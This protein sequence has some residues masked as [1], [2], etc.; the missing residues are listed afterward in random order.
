MKK[1][2]VILVFLLAISLTTAEY[3]L[4]IK[5]D[6]Q[7]Y[8]VGE[9]LAYQALLLEDGAP[10][11][12]QV[13]V[14]FSDA[15]EK[16]QITETV[17]SNIENK[18]L[19]GEDFTSGGWKVSATYKEKTVESRPFLIK[20][21]TAVEFKIQGKKLIITNKGNTPYQKQIQI[22]IGED[23]TPQSV[24]IGVGKTKELTLVAPEGNY[25]IKVTDGEN[26]VTKKA[27]YLTG[28]GNAIGAYDENLLSGGLIGGTEDP[29]NESFSSSSKMPIALIFVGAVFGLGILFFIERRLS[30]KKK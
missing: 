27:V 10:I 28:T 15:L 16:K 17:T 9:E 4:D 11:G 5:L 18:L 7:E 1:I 19:I 8:A 13:I 25:D 12:D 22:I 14:T 29:D 6:K 23:I 3:S 21:N 26:S 24:S 30:N 2:A 20:Q